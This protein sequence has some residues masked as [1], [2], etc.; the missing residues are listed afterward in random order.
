ML[1][2]HRWLQEYV[3]VRLSPAK[4]AEELSMLGLEIAS[5]E[6]QSKTYEGFVVGE[7]LTVAKHPHADRLT[8]CEVNVGREKLQIVCG[9]P[10]VEAGQK[11]AVGLVGATIPHNQHDP[12]GMPFTL[13][14]ATIRNVESHG[15]ICS[16]YELGLGEDAGG[17]LVLDG[18]AKVGTPL[19]KH[20]GRTDVIYETEVTAN[21]GDWL[22]HFGVAR[23][24]AALLGTRMRR[25]AIRLRESKMKASRVAAVKI[26]DIEKCPRYSARV[27][28]G[29]SIAPSPQ[30]LKDRLTA[31]GMRPINNVVDV[32]NYVMLETGQPLHAFDFD[33]LAGHTVVV[34]SAT[35]GQK[36]TTL[37][38]KERE[39][40]PDILM[41]CDA[42]R[43]VAVAGVMGGLDSEIS[44]RTTNILLE[45]ACFN[46]GSIR[47]ASKFLGLSTDASQRFERATDIEMTTYALDRA[48]QLL[49]EIAGVEILSGRIDVY[50]ARR[51]QKSIRLSVQAANSI[52]GTDLTQT[53]IKRYLQR[54]ELDA[55]PMGRDA[56]SIAVPSFRNDLTSEIDL[57]EE[58]ARMHGYDNI[59][60]SL[61]TTVQLR[62]TADERAVR[63][64][65][66]QLCIGVGFQEILANSLLDSR[67]AA[68][69]GG[70][71]IKILN[72]VSV[73]MAYVR[74]SLIPGA[75]HVVRHNR[76]H[77][78]RD[79]RLFEIGNVASSTGGNIGSFDAIKQEERLLLLMTGAHMPPGY[80]IEQ[81]KV[82]MFDL[83]GVVASVLSKF[84]LDKRCFISYDRHNSLSE[85]NLAIEI[86]GTY[87]GLLGSVKRS[88]LDHF[89]L[90]DDVLV[91]ELNTEL[92]GLNWNRAKKFSP[93]PR[94]PVVARDLAFIV[95]IDLPQL[96]VEDAIR[97]SGGEM[98]H[99]ITL[100][101]MFVGKQIGAGKKSLAYALEFQPTEK[102]LTVQEID[103]II[104]G[105]VKHVTASCSAALRSLS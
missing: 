8:V 98:L 31:V 92:L 3:D 50:P 60:T 25:P 54:L 68:L 99:R 21:R 10:N 71:A 44:E 52:L 33:T 39:L 76:S 65:L 43:P 53:D 63:D 66:R 38:G 104:A 61:R 96:K 30:W 95:D 94:Y 80:G 11:V 100:F 12:S 22:S 67:T 77:G 84:S 20:L 7:V 102:T 88:V 2:S 51:K 91:C 48:A 89:G 97:E 81:R 49:Q 69:A 41:I 32:T 40:S 26:L 29:V 85:G 72:P 55:R 56:L 62:T 45:S 28:R 64:E 34:K 15:M 79:L 1:I 14:R 78:Q 82:D 42:E 9:A 90:E 16:A 75:L 19:A 24:V 93:I 27:L 70:G 101:D 23:E 35:R 36:F 74:T 58:V 83:K 57:I 4:L 5:V 17:I 46:A 103:Q 37:D 47:K 13:T 73:E 87:V 6:E 18:S 86:N 105:V 59:E